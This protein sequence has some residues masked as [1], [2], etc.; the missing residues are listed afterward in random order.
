[1]RTKVKE[2]DY[3]RAIPLFR[4]GILRIRTRLLPLWTRLHLDTIGSLFDPSTGLPLTRSELRDA[5]SDKAPT[6]TRSRVYALASILHRYQTRIPIFITSL[7]T[8]PRKYSSGEVVRCIDDV[9]MGGAL[10]CH[11]GPE[12]V[13]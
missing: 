12:M 4:N 5:V 11:K 6:L 1:M 9:S 10:R 8:L 7:I 13:V 3:F 2:P